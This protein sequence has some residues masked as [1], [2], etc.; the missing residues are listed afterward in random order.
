MMFKLEEILK[1]TGA[2]LIKG[3][4]G[5]E[6]YNIS[7]DTRTVKSGEIYLPLKGASFDGENF[8]QNAIDAGAA[9]CFITGKNYPDDAQIVLK[10][11]NTLQAYLKIAN[12]YRN[13]INPKV[14]AITGS[15]GKTTTKELVYSV[16]SEK[17]KA[18]KTFSNH[19]KS[20]ME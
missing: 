13:K 2:E 3:T 20:R 7:T 19:I 9:G 4:V 11:E 18:H 10:V 5:E 16:V 15:S 14:V 12:F 1:A 6:S 8:L 17:F